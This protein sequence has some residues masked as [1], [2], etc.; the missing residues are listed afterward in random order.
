MAK[1]LLKGL[2]VIA[3]SIL[4]LAAAAWLW[5]AP[6]ERHGEILFTGGEIVTVTNGTAEALL[7]KGGRIA[8]VGARADVEALASDDAHHIDLEGDALLPGLIEPHTHPIAA[9]TLGAAVDVS[10]FM[11]TSRA[12]VMETLREATDGWHPNGWIVAFGWDPVMIEDMAAP[13]LAELD[14]IAPD[15]PLVILTQ[16]MHDAFANS[17]A[18]SAAGITRNTPNPPGGEFVRDEGGAL[19]GTVRELGAIAALLEHMPRPP[20]GAAELL[21]NMKLADYARAGITTLAVTGPVGNAPDPL[22]LLAGLYRAHM[23][24]VQLSIYATPNQLGTPGTPDAPTKNAGVIGVKVWM[25]GSPYAGGAA[26]E[27]PYA[28]TPLT[29]ERLH[30]GKGHRGALNYPAQDFEQML[31]AYHRAGYQIA[32]HVQG[33]R[34]INRTLDVMERMLAAN[35]R[36]DHRH[37]LEHN[38][39]I[40]RPQL[41]RAAALGMT[42]S[43]FID[44]I[45]FYGHRLPDLIG[46][47]RTARYMPLRDALDAGLRV[48]LH[49]DTPATPIGP[50]RAMKAAVTRQP[51]A[52]GPPL[53]PDQRLTRQE[54]LRAI[55]IDAAWQLGLD[56]ERGSLEPGKATDLVRLVA[57]PLTEDTD[58]IDAIGVK[59]TWIGGKQTDTRTATRAN[60]ALLLR[61]VP[62]LF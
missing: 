34:A 12:G 5:M 40:T 2:A 42:T 14:A 56:R 3:G 15:T 41:A 4:L 16:M 45:T 6:P 10:G 58:R 9:S 44:H 53:A 37:R 21:L 27:E 30:L 62:G 46:G 36:K 19:T 33:E 52:G 39:L 26:L 18:L 57:N 32:V 22:G 24:S 11:H 48:S 29:A 47:A 23:P 1:K 54:A 35:P 59:A 28:H 50:L 60:A 8:A 38:A 61:L 13:T 43:F 20:A 31:A 7:V 17:A 51:R 55:T 25:D 49:T